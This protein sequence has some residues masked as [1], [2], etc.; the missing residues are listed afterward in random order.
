MAADLLLA[1]DGGGT[2]TRA[3][4]ADLEGRVLAR[5]FGPGSNLQ[6]V[7]LQAVGAALTTAIEGALLQLPG[8]IHKGEG[9]AW[10]SGR[11]AAAC[12]GLAGVDSKQD[13][14]HIAAWVK[15]QAIAPK[16]A[17]LNDSELVLAC[18]TPDGVGVA[19]ISGTGSICLGR[20]KDGRTARAGG[21]GPLVGD[22][23]SGHELSVR[24]LRLAVRTTDG[25]S[26]SPALLRAALAH[27]AQPDAQA[28]VNHLH[29]PGTTPAD[30]ASFGTTVVDLA[31]K[32]DADADQL[33][34]DA[35]A[36]LVTHVRVVMR[37]LRLEKPPLALAGGVL[38][39]QVRT[40]LVGALGEEIGPVTHV[41]DPVAGAVTLARRML[42]G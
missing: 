29:T 13:E 40:L 14:A 24:A 37:A 32:G 33:V 17:V 4:V 39:S 12:F 22:E 10:R 18:G 41:A 30:I 34:N 42:N 36:E 26:S 16:F 35:V 21:W 28:L 11:L 9:P 5:G 6:T 19:L 23:G 7:G 15:D 2:R 25:R 31:A 8:G 1:V 3:A 38:R 20:A 27:F